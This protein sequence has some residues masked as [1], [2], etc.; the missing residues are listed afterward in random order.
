MKKGLTYLGGLPR[1]LGLKYR[2][3]S[4]QKDTL[5]STYIVRV[6]RA[7]FVTR[8]RLAW[9]HK[10]GPDPKRKDLFYLC[11]YIYSHTHSDSHT[12]HVKLTVN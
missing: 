7:F 11:I 12:L 6:L 10:E 5:G 4:V 1:Q 9:P 2:S 8:D 3:L